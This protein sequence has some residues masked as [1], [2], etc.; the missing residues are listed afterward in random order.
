MP[1][2]RKPVPAGTRDVPVPWPFFKHVTLHPAKRYV[3]RSAD[4]G[5]ILYY[6]VNFRWGWVKLYLIQSIGLLQF[7]EDKFLYLCENF[8]V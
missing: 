7:I 8:E 2:K 6:H 5:V 1:A 3:K 4:G